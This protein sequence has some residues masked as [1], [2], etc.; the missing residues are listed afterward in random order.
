MHSSV[1]PLLETYGYWVVFLFVGIESLG[2]PLPGETAL[3]T[4]AAFAALGHLSIAGVI[5]T[6]AAGAVMGD[7][8]GY[9]IGRTGGLQLV[10]KYGRI[11]RFD[12]AKLDRVRTFFS[13][14][15]QRRCFSEGSLRCCAHGQLY[16]PERP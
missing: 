7:A 10:R 2:I 16:S 14:H 3:V 12:E 4:A 5:A 13:R 15:G 11:V 6:A 9:W 8:C 1:G